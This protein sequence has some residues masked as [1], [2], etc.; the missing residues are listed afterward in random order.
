MPGAADGKF[1]INQQTIKSV[2]LPVPPLDQQR[3]IVTQMQ[4]SDSKVAAEEQCMAALQALFKT[5]LSQ[6]MTGKVRLRGWE[7]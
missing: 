7:Q 3:K 6:L 4:V 2:L 1:N 5:M